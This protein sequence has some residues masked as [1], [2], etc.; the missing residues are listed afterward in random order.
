MDEDTSE[1][2][3]FTLSSERGCFKAAQAAV[4]E[5]MQGED[6]AVRMVGIYDEKRKGREVT[7]EECGLL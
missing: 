1:L 4:M 5:D 7:E 6:N 2:L 3:G